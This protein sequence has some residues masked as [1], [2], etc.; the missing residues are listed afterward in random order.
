MFYHLL[1]IYVLCGDVC[2]VWLGKSWYCIICSKYLC[3]LLIYAYL[4]DN[5]V[6]SYT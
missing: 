5:A 2:A 3:I 6:C 4:N 1:Q